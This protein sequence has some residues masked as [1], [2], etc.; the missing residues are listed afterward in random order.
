MIALEWRCKAFAALSSDE[1]YSILKLRNEVFVVEQNCVFQDAD[2]KDQPS[3]H[4]MGWLNDQ[5]AA[6]ARLV[7]EGVTYPYVSIGR[8]VTSPK[9]RRSGAG[10]AL[11]NKAIETCDTLFGQQT[12][13]IGAQLYLKDFY[14]QFGFVEIGEEYD[15]DGIPH[16]HMLRQ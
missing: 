7:P 14:R 2:D 15:E 4:L 13:K 11:M 12:I 6:Y 9:V 5:L 16:I 3:Y 8:V 10:K 1:M